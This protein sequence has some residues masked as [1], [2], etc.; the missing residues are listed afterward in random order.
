MNLDP[1]TRYSDEDLWRV[2][3]E[4]SSVVPDLSVTLALL[5]PVPDLSVTLALLLPLHVSISL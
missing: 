4:V 3:E 5:L 2:A 1:H